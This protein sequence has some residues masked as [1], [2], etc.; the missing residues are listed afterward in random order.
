MSVALYI[1][2][3]RQI[4][5]FDHQVNGNALGRAGKLLDVLAERAGTKPL[6]QFFSASPQEMSEFAASS[7]TGDRG[8]VQRFFHPN[9]GSQ[10]K[11]V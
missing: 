7:W 6:L 4:L 3:E 8:K 10:Q 9:A 1:V 5:G 11:R 2:L